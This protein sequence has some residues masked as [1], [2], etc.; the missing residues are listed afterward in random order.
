L[1]VLRKEMFL[2]QTE[3]FHASESIA[4]KHFNSQKYTKAHWIKLR[5]E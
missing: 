5:G 3:R 2:K 4:K 1:E